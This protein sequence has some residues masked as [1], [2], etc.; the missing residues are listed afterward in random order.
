MDVPAQAS[1][2]SEVGTLVA[3]GNAD[4]SASTAKTNADLAAAV[5][6]KA[7]TKGGKFTQ[8]AQ[9]EEG[10][11]KAA[12]ASAVNKVLGILN[13]IIRKTVSSNLERVKESI[14]GIK[15]SET[16]VTDASQS[17]VSK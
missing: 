8:A 15:Y 14:K 3:G 6:L 4:N 9:N 1:P 17:V 13:V 10:A 11:V 5:A 16:S 7:M 12:A 2:S